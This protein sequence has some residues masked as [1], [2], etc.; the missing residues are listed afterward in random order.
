MEEDITNKIYTT[1]R[2]VKDVQ[3][4]CPKCKKNITIYDVDTGEYNSIKCSSCGCKV[5]FY[6]SDFM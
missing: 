3:Y 5:K 6:V 1:H 4:V 2:E